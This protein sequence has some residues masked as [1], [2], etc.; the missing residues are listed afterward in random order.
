MLRP[1]ASSPRSVELLSASGSPAVDAVAHVDQRPLVDA[2]ALVGAHELLE[3]VLVQLAAPSGLDL[4]AVGGHRGDHAVAAGDDDLAGVEGRLGLHAGAHD[5]RLRLRRGTA[6]RCMLE[7][8]R[9][10][11]ASSCSRNGIRAV[12]TETICLGLTSMYSIWS[13]RASGNWSR[14]RVD[15]RSSTKWPASSRR[16]VGLGDVVVLLVVRVEVHDLVGHAR[17]DGERGGLLLLELG[18]GLAGELRRPSCRTTVPLLVARSAPAI[19]RSIV[20]I[21]VRD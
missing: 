9:A 20:G 21:V 18:D 16:G 3:A 12:A 17:A 5:G 7:P 1:R 11:L 10:R 19:S 13:G 15:T 4:D 14:W 2:G 6:W 8:M